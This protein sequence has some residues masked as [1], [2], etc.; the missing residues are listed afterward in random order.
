MKKIIVICA[1]F[2]SIH[3]VAQTNE[4]EIYKEAIQHIKEDNCK[5]AIQ[6]FEKIIPSTKNKKLLKM[7]LIFKS[8]CL[9]KLGKY[10]EGLSAINKAIQLDTTDVASYFDKIHV[11][12]AMKRHDKIIDLCKALQKKNL[13][14]KESSNCYYYLGLAYTS[15]G[16][17][18]EAIE[19][20]TY[21]I[22]NDSTEFVFYFY[23][24]FAYE[25]YDKLN[26]AEA[27]YTQA[28]KF[29]ENSGQSYY[30]RGI[31]RVA[32]VMEENHGTFINVLGRD[33]CKDLKKAKELGVDV[34]RYNIYCN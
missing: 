19:A 23:R 34:S 10:N 1:L 11:L 5:E 3:C 27:D 17:F 6:K 25:K 29:N 14:K 15:K 13:N 21:S 26:K 18:T 20:L 9:R 7:S 30:R 28:I 32:K 16:Q 22:K 8:Q 2:V 4:I 24:G 31:V 12:K 33:A